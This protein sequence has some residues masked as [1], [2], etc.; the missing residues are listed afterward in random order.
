MRGSAHGGKSA[1]D[2]EGDP[3]PYDGDNDGLAVTDTGADEWLPGPAFLTVL[4]PAL[5]SAGTLG[6]SDP[7]PQGI[8][9][10]NCGS[11]DAFQ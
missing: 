3:R 10:F 8:D 7:A 2:F 4:P 11:R 1:T 5:N 9:I 6:R